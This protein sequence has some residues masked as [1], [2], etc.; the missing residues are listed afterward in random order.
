MQVDTGVGKTRIII[1]ELATFLRE[2][3]LNGPIIYAVPQHALS[4]EILKRFTDHG[5]NARIFR[6]RTAIDPEKF[7]PTLLVK[8]QL[9]MCLRNDNALKL[10]MLSHAELTESCCVKGKIKCP[11]INEC[12]YFGQQQDADEVQVWIVAA[13]TLFH[14][15]KVFGKP[16]GVLIDEGI[17][18]KGWAQ[19]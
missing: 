11:R 16:A 3:N 2:V 19:R 17:W 12:G 4:K 5:I 7:D 14:T 15:H 8:D 10:G 9:L 1:E 18:Q 6:G 13:D